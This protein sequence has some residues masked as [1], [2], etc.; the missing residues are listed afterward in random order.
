MNPHAKALAE[1]L[2]EE[3]SRKSYRRMAAEDYP[4]IAPGTLCRIAKSGGKWLP[5]D[6]RILIAL[7]LKKPP[8][9]RELPEWMKRWRRLPKETREAVI[10]EAVNGDQD[11]F[12]V[13]KAAQAAER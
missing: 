11:I 10:R 9:H 6:R 7:G 1:R 13:E 4:G 3:H 2:L 12:Q 5:K 8:E